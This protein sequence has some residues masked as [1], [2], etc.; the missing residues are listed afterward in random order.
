M[1]KQMPASED[2]V[3]KQVPKDER[4]LI[5][6]YLDVYLFVDDV[7]FGGPRFYAMEITLKDG[8]TDYDV[9]AIIG[10]VTRVCDSVEFDKFHDDPVILFKKK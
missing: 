6:N 1:A 8:C 4:Q 2:Q 3:E 5:S 7:W 9:D 10:L